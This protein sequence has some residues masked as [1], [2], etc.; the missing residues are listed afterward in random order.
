[1]HRTLA[2]RAVSLARCR[3]RTATIT[4]VRSRVGAV[5]LIRNGVDDDRYYYHSGDGV[6]SWEPPAALADAP[7]LAWTECWDAEVGE[8]GCE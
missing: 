3:G 8:R 1:M 4:I 5:V 7:L 6:S 2:R